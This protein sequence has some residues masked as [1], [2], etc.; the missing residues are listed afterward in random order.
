MAKNKDRADM[1]FR[2]VLVEVRSEINDFC[3]E[4]DL[5][6]RDFLELAI[7]TL[8][9]KQPQDEQGPKVLAVE[10][11]VRQM[12]RRIKLYEEVTKVQA[13]IREIEHPLALSESGLDASIREK[14]LADLQDMKAK[15]IEKMDSL[16][17]DGN[18]EDAFARASLSQTKPDRVETNLESL[19]GRFRET[20]GL[21]LD[22]Y[23]KEFG[24]NAEV[25]EE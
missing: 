15:L 20:T 13:K 12:G 17:P 6:L 10:Q 5:K 14:M 4:H 21:D 22:S 18:V 24:S 2:G 7:N 25:V 16:L 3:K 9:K 11:T 8:K 1:L 23:L 19:K